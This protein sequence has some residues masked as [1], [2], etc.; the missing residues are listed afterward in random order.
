MPKA[1]KSLTTDEKLR[2]RAARKAEA[3]NA[4][5]KADAGPLYADQVPAEDFANATDEY[6][7]IRK[8]WADCQRGHE[9]AYLADVDHKVDLMIIRNLARRVMPPAD[10]A[11]AVEK[12]GQFGS[13]MDF[14][15]N[16]LLGRRRIVIHYD[17]VSH[18]WRPVFR[19]PAAVNCCEHKCH[20]CESRSLGHYEK[21]TLAE[22]LVW[23][24]AGYQ[25]PMTPEQLESHLSLPMPVDWPGQV[26]PL[27]LSKVP[28]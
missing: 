1:K 17:R 8:S 6:W 23:P 14:W 21:V 10:F 16:I 28:Q 3:T 4:R 27:G 9:A 15:R 25:A 2:R 26:D 11:L 20:R 12:D 24:P 18:G 13:R 5:I 22:S 7:R 19:D